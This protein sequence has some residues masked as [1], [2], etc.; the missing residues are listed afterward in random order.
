M[1]GVD[2]HKAD[3]EVNSIIGDLKRKKVTAPEM[4]KV[5]NKYESANIYGN[6]NILNKALNLAYY[7][8]LG[9]PEMINNEVDLY[10][11]TDKAMVTEAAGKYFDSSNCST[12]FYK[13]T[14]D[15]GK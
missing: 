12:L 10:R 14:R 5:K 1:K 6:T 2:I 15:H 4:E 3:N 8:L 9:S 13:S 7:E 11:K